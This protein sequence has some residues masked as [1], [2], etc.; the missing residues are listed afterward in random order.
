MERLL[1]TYERVAHIN[2][3][4]DRCCKH[5]E[6]GDQ[7]QGIVQVTDLHGL[8]VFKFHTNPPCDFPKVPDCIPAEDSEGLD[9]IVNAA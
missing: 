2:H 5:I 3:Y 9:A 6:P 4:C 7:Y 8:I 1:R